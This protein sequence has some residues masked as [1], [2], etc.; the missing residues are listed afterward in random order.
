MVSKHNLPVRFVDFFYIAPVNKIA[1]MALD[2]RRIVQHLQQPRQ[3]IPRNGILLLPKLRAVGMNDY[4]F[5][6][7][8]S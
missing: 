8:R 3:G 6:A 5:G 1:F 2:E 7:T 4:F